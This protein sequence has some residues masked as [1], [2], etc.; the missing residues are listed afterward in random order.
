MDS[1]SIP[2]STIPGKVYLVRREGEGWTCECVAHE[3]GKDCK[4]IEKVKNRLSGETGEIKNY[5][6]R[7]SG[8]ANVSREDYEWLSARLSKN[9]DL[10]FRFEVIG[11][12][13]DETKPNN[14]DGTYDRVRAIK[15]STVLFDQIQEI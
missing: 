2:S 3:M 8:K 14:H 5:W 15:I 9:P 13:V 10:D 7:V 11:A 6:I 1:Y 4:H 12:S